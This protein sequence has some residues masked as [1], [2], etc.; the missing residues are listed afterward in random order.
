MAKK[1]SRS[2]NVARKREKRNRDRKNRN[3]Q[4]AAEKHRR[5][6]Y[7]KMD[8]ER[9][10]N[11]LIK[12]RELLNEPEF[13]NV[14]FD[15]DMM[16][17]EI[18][19]L[20][21]QNDFI[22]VPKPRVLPI[23]EHVDLQEEEPYFI[24]SDSDDPE[25]ICEMFRTDVLPRL[26]SPKF[27]RALLSA[28]SECENRFL[29]IGDR[30]RAEVA[31]VTHTLFEVVPNHILVEHPL[32][33]DIGLKTMQF[34][35]DAPPSFNED[36]SRVRYILT[37]VLGTESSEFQE[38]NISNILSDGIVGEKS[39]TQNET[40]QEPETQQSVNESDIPPPIS[41]P[42]PSPDTL[43]AKA[44]YKNFDGMAIK[45]VLKEWQN[46][47]LE[48]ETETQL[49]LFN[50]NQELYITITENRIQLHAHSDEKLSS[51]MKEL[52]AYCQSGIMYLAK[53]IEEGG[54]PDAT[55]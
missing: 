19:R 25:E 29:R 38:G 37:D 44:L 6:S 22:M 31:F 1:K 35:V 17:D 12:S 45:N 39:F 10:H 2:A 42:L 32:I 8:E 13:E 36:S 47:S 23:T 51:A 18:Y 41:K 15:I 4:I 24:N 53:T 55:E 5:P 3:R 14:H 52:E 16:F 7:G 9:L 20:I 27:M 11:C 28:L 33:I 30:E 46:E 48:K 54:I 40:H 34:L 49:D 21:N 26:I 50:E 43:P